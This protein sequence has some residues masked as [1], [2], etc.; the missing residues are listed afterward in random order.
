MTIT[1]TFHLTTP[2]MVGADVQN[3]QQ[4]LTRNKCYEGPINGEYD[5]ITA[6]GVFRAKYWLGYPKPD[7]T[8]AQLLELYLSGTKKPTVLMRLRTKARLSAKKSNLLLG[9]IRQQA[10][11]EAITHLGEHEVPP[12]SNRVPFASLWY[13][14]IGPWCAM[15]VTHCYVK[16]G[17][18]VFQRGNRY[19]YVPY[20][21]ADARAGRNNL[22]VTLNP[23]PGDIIAYDWP[24]ESPGIADHTGLFEK[25]IDRNAG[26]FSA[27]EGNTSDANN[28]NG[29]EVMRRERNVSLVQCFIHVGK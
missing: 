28:S 3:L 27:I 1:R 22:T 13:G 14:A 7:H 9:N 23:Q 26:T 11:K 4:L 29:G 20:I 10:L 5:P 15:F 8:A 17:S 18:T 16:A 19:A 6:Q 25:W 21:V 24:G 2:H 12:G